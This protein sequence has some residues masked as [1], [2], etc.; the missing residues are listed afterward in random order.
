MSESCRNKY[1][2]AIHKIRN[3]GPS[4]LNRGDDGLQKSIPFGGS[5]RVR[6]SS[7]C[8]KYYWN[9]SP[10]I[11]DSMKGIRTKCI[12]RLLDERLLAAG[13]DE[14]V[15][16][17]AAYEYVNLVLAK[18]EGEKKKKYSP[19]KADTVAGKKYLETSVLR[20]VSQEGLDQMVES[21]EDAIL[22]FL[23]AK[24]RSGEIDALM[25]KLAA[26]KKGDFLF[27]EALKDLS[28]DGTPPLQAAFFG[29]MLAG[30]SEESIE[31]A[32]R[33]SHAISTEG[34]FDEMEGFSAVDTLKRDVFKDLLGAGHLGTKSL[35][36]QC[37][38]EFC[39]I[40]M[41][42]LEDNLARIESS[43]AELDVRNILSVYLNA[44][45]IESS[46]SGSSG[47]NASPAPSAILIE[48]QNGGTSPFDYTNAYHT[49][50]RGN[51]IV[52]KSQRRLI[53]ECF[54]VDK[55]FGSVRNVENR[56]WLSLDEIYEGEA[57]SGAASLHVINE[58]DR[59]TD[60][61]SMITEVCNVVL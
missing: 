58:A 55:A 37:M 36:S 53:D 40:D 57:K 28:I 49:P 47:C 33:V 27:E 22:G 4:A 5:R 43:G 61:Q 45:I 17:R 39:Y 6:I 16:D 3:Y 56:M 46:R 32:V 1:K 34:M 60:I 13:L 51:N 15:A 59:Y 52:E 11:P 42:V 54:K 14:A 7:Q 38:Y 35:T 23:D 50:V 8:Q 18:N 9:D 19:P 48:I 31:A 41:G 29:R 25:K 12:G 30:D 10:L 44:I 21:A 26:G 24:E 20:F 2:V